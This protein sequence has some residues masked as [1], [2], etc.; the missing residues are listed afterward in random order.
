M[1]PWNL[2]PF[3]NNNFQK[4]VSGM[5]PEE[6]DQYIQ[7]IMK[8]AFQENFGSMMNPADL[9]HG[10]PLMNNQSPRQTNSNSS[11]KIQA[12]VFETHD[13]VYARIPVKDEEWLKQLRVYHTSNQLI[14]EHVPEYDDKETITL[15]AIV[16]RKGSTAQY[17]EGTLEIKIPKNIDMQYS[18]ID[19]KE[20]Y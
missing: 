17:K 20:I 13:Y 9:A 1:F 12:A 3:H 14:L 4:M 10:F 18:E 5:K 6:I 2:F 8:K 15:P 11:S 19:V 16:K 7:D